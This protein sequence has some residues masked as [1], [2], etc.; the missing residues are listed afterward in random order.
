MAELFYLDRDGEKKG[1][2]DSSQL[3]VLAQ[4]GTITPDTLIET[5]NGER[6]IAKISPNLNFFTPPIPP[7]A[8]H[9]VPPELPAVAIPSVVEPPVEPAAGDAIVENMVEPPVQEEAE[10]KDVLP[11]SNVLTV[12]NEKLETLSQEIAFANKFAEKKQEQIDK[13]YEENRLYK[14]G[15]IEKFKEKLVMGIIEQ[16]SQADRQVQ[17]FEKKEESEKSYK[18]L[19]EAFRELTDDFREMLAN[20]FNVDAYRSEVGE[21]FDAA[22]HQ[23]LPNGF[24]LTE[25]ETKERTIVSSERV[26]YISGGKVLRQEIV[27][28]HRYQATPSVL[29]P[30]DETPSEESA[31]PVAETQET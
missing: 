13:L 2:I 16:L 11:D 18:N 20:R 6:R 26:G 15:I 3:K 1:P 9:P 17:N 25:D 28:I 23:I 31:L 21:Q 29:P 30:A 14:D 4:N 7:E 24:I 5:E 8:A 12:I 19:L 22:K 10:Q 27:K